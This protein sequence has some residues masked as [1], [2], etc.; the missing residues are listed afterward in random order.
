MEIPGADGVAGHADPVGV[1]LPGDDMDMVDKGVGL[2]ALDGQIRIQQDAAGLPALELAFPHVQLGGKAFDPLK[3]LRLQRDIPA[4][5]LVPEEAEKLDNGGGIALQILHGLPVL[6]GIG[7]VIREEGFTCQLIHPGKRGK[8]PVIHAVAQA[9][10]VHGLDPRQTQHALHLGKGGKLIDQGGFLPIVPGGHQQSQHIG[11]AELLLDF[12]PGN[13]LLVLL[14]HRHDIHVIGVAAVAVA[15]IGQDHQQHEQ[16]RDHAAGGIGKFPHKGDLGD[17][18]FVPCPVHQPAK[19][20]QQGG[21]QQKDGQKAAQYGL[22][23]HKAHVRPQT[24]LHEGH[25]RQAR[26]G[27]QAA[28]GDLRDGQRQGADH[29]LF[30]GEKPVLLLVAVAEDDGIVHR[31]GQ[32]QHNGHG[33]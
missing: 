28:G 13:I 19:Q 27:G 23:E 21:H 29:G 10:A 4:L 26:D 6:P 9:A 31:Q 22:D 1:I 11:G 30:F 14:W 20:H 3:L 16:G 18:A 12:F 24:K 8:F 17:K 15:E 2:L 5:R 25:G 7:G 32:L 33:V